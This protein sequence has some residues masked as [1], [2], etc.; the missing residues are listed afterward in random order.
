MVALGRLVELANKV[1]DEGEYFGD[2]ESTMD[3]IGGYLRGSVG[4]EELANGNRGL[5]CLRDGE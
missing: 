2:E 1:E 3:G 4:F 5:V